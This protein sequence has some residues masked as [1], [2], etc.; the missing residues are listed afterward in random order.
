MFRGAKHCPVVAQGLSVLSLGC[1]DGME[2]MSLSKH[3]YLLL[4]EM[5]ASALPCLREGGKG[6]HLAAILN[7]VLQQGVEGA[8]ER[9]VVSVAGGHGSPLGTPWVG[10]SSAGSGPWAIWVS[11]LDIDGH[12]KSFS[13][14]AASD[15]VFRHV[16]QPDTFSRSLLRDF[17]D[18]YLSFG[19]LSFLNN[20]MASEVKACFSPHEK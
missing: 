4:F 2:G 5:S 14:V 19:D 3:R 6:G 1:G 13:S 7:Q 10:I 17:R 20:V 9:V 15:C 12:D 8:Q 16:Q 11:L 18:R